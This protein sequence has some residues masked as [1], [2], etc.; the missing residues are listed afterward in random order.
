MTTGPRPRCA[1]ATASAD[2]LCDHGWLAD[3]SGADAKIGAGGGNR[4]LVFS[5]EGCCSTIELH[6]RQ[7]L[8]GQINLFFAK[9]L[10]ECDFK[11]LSNSKALYLSGNAEYQTSF[12]GMNLAVCLD[13]PAL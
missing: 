1:G 10:P 8:V 9:A 3:R 2:N 7:G 13:L 12:Q 5:L 6:P 11:Y 4:T